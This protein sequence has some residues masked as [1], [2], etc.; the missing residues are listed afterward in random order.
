VKEG[1]IVVHAVYRGKEHTDKSKVPGAGFE[2][3]TSGFLIR[4]AQAPERHTADYESGAPTRMSYPGMRKSIAE[5]QYDEE[6]K[7]F[8]RS[9]TAV[10]DACKDCCKPLL[11]F[12]F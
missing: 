6:K 7:G 10:H 5:Q 11:Y 1:Q 8:K 12:Y 3:A 9:G 4:P 2:P